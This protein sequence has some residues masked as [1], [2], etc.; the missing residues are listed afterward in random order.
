MEYIRSFIA[1]WFGTWQHFFALWGWLPAILIAGL[2]SGLLDAKQGARL[3]QFVGIPLIMWA[4]VALTHVIYALILQYI[5]PPI[6]ARL[7]PLVQ[8]P[9]GALYEILGPATGFFLLSCPFV[10]LV[11]LPGGDG[12]LL[13]VLRVVFGT[14]AVVA[15]C[16]GFYLAA[17]GLGKNLATAFIY[18]GAMLGLT[19]FD[20]SKLNTMAT[21][22]SS[23]T[24]LR[25]FK[26]RRIERAWVKDR[27]VV[28]RFGLF[29]AIIALFWFGVVLSEAVLT[30]F[31]SAAISG[32]L[33]IIGFAALVFTFIYEAIP[34][35]RLRR[36]V[37]AD[38][39]S[40]Q[41]AAT[42]AVVASIFGLI[43]TKGELALG[44]PNPDMMGSI[45]AGLFVCAFGG[46]V[47]ATETVMMLFRL[48]ATVLADLGNANAPATVIFDESRTPDVNSATSETATG[49]SELR[50]CLEDR[51]CNVIPLADAPWESLAGTRRLIL[52][53]PRVN[54]M[55]GNALFQGYARVIEDGN[56]LL[57]L[58]DPQD[59]EHK[60]AFAQHFGF[61]EPQLV[62]GENWLPVRCAEA[63]G[64]AGRSIGAVPTPLIFPQDAGEISLFELA[65]GEPDANGLITTQSVAVAR[66][67]GN[68]W[69]VIASSVPAFQNAQLQQS[70]DFRL[71]HALFDQLMQLLPET[72][73]STL[74]P[75]RLTPRLVH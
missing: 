72:R 30:T 44:A 50:N 18:G 28:V 70:R 2:I 48:V 12:R 20:I 38:T 25:G 57:M 1:D 63:D 13:R 61:S 6:E 27:T 45:R 26:I 19:S 73:P 56:I 74:A 31:Y 5:W 34:T 62:Q 69:V 14:W 37:A 9:Y 29:L 49:L 10:V 66:R 22:Y 65:S 67:L 51:G 53:I 8:T 39:R 23:E 75:R 64:S 60:R 21:R 54:Q 47:L 36:E 55:L 58:T 17:N 4:I 59:W 68:G 24:L 32:L 41:Q 3:G 16:I 42:I 43:L 33:T 46:L 71:V 15:G 7:G 11:L 35:M 52:V 40:V